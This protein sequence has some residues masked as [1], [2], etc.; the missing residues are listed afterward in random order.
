MKHY[1]WLQNNFSIFDYVLWLHKGYF[2][3]FKASDVQNKFNLFSYLFVQNVSCYKVEMYCLEIMHSTF[4]GQTSS[5]FVLRKFKIE[6]FLTYKLLRN[7]TCIRHQYLSNCMPYKGLEGSTF[8]FL[9]IYNF[10]NLIIVKK[11]LILNL[12]MKLYT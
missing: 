1:L 7:W 3:D 12:W 2:V 8:L 4:T 5:I 6:W 11:I 9:R 10:F